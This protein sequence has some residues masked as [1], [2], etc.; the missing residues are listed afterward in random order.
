YRHV[1][2]QLIPRF[3]WPDK[4]RS[5]VATY[6]LSIY[7][8]LQQEADTETTTIAFGLLA[9]AFANFGMIG[10]VLLGVFWGVTLKK[11]QLWST[12]SPMFSCAGLM[13]VLLTAWA[14]SAELTMAAWFSSFQQAVVVVLGVPFLIKSLLGD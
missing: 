11:L 9:E 6:E 8:G 1:L 5:H 4:P 7:Y 13:M 2:P 3:F 14:F 12:F 10:S